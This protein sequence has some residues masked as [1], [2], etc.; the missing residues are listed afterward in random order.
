MLQAKSKVSKRTVKPKGRS[1]TQL[2]IYLPKGLVN[3]SAF[4]FKADDAIMIRVD[5]EGLRIEPAK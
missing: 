3:D 5:G 1:Y 2:F 4:P